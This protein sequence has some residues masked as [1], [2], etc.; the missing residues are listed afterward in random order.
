MYHAVQSASLVQHFPKGLALTASFWWALEAVT[1]AEN[2]NKSDVISLYGRKF[3]PLVWIPLEFV[4]PVWMQ[5]IQWV[6]KYQEQ[7]WLLLLFHTERCGLFGDF[8]IWNVEPIFKE[9]SQI[10]HSSVVLSY[11][12]LQNI[13][14]VFLYLMWSFSYCQVV[15]TWTTSAAAFCA[16]YTRSTLI[17]SVFVQ[18]SWLPTL[19]VTQ[20]NCLLYCWDP[21]EDKPG[22]IADA[23]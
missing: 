19:V 9:H 8:F 18:G 10:C 6:T 1:S 23:V 14:T 21:A 15:P 20:C 5:G 13:Y 11:L 12:S 17:S 16:A 2:C 22:W 7:V 4:F 3:L